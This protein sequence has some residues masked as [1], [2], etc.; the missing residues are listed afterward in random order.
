MQLKWECYVL[1]GP[2]SKRGYGDTPRQALDNLAEDAAASARLAE[3]GA[4]EWREQAQRIREE[5]A[6]L[7][8]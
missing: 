3:Q 7:G 8:G 5:R 6:A 2:S 1:N 4:A